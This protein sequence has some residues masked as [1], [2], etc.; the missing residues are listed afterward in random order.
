MKTIHTKSALFLSGLIL[1][2]FLIPCLT[3]AGQ[4]STEGSEISLEN[5]PPNQVDSILA[6][7]SNEQIRSLL[8][9]ELANTSADDK[10][11]NKQKDGLV[12]KASILLHILDKE[13]NMGLEAT[14]LFSS[15]AKIPS[16]YIQLAKNIGNGSFGAFI[17]A[18]LLFAAILGAAFLVEFIS[19]RF[20]ADFSRQFQ[21]KA[22]P[23]LDGPMRFIAGIMRAVPAVILILVFGTTAILL[24]FLTAGA[25]YGPQ[26]YLF[27][28]I[29]FI[30]LFFRLLSQLSRI[31][32]AP[33]SPSLRVLPLADST[34][35]ALHRSILVLFT[36]TFAVVI[37]LALFRELQMPMPSLRINVMLSASGLI[38]L[39]AIG[40]LR[41]RTS[42]R[43]RILARSEKNKTRNWVIEQFAAFWHVPTLLYFIIIWLIMMGDQ[44]NG[45]QRQNSAFLM[46]LLILP[47][48]VVFNNIG[49]WVVRLSIKT[50]RIYNS[51][52][53]NPEDDDYEEK[54]ANGEKKELD[55]IVT[56][57]RFMSLAILASLLIWVLEL[58]GIELP[59]ATKF[60]GA[61]F[62]A[63]IIIAL[64]L[65]FWRFASSYI[66]RKI[67]ESMPEKTDEEESDDEWGAAADR[68]RS[69]TL[70]PMLRKVLASTLLVMV[71]LL[72][73]SAMGMDIGPLLAGA[74]V[75]GLAIGFGAQKLVSDIF[76]GFFYL[77]DDAF[78]VGEYI[79]AGPVSG[80]VEAITLRNVMLRHHR[81]MLQ[82]VPHSDLG[83]ITNF[84]RGGIIVKFNL[85]FPYDANVDN[86]RKVIKKVG[87]AM[88]ED[89][90]FG[91]DF[92]NPVKSAGVREITG[93]VMVI[94]VK[95]KAQP[96]THFVIRR[97]AYRRITEALAAQGIHYAHRKVIVELPEHYEKQLSEQEKAIL[98]A[99]AA[100]EIAQQEE[101]AKKNSMKE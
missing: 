59:Y 98:K 41:I 26:R 78:R 14:S 29:L 68:G 96:G 71:T 77:L 67:A 36:Y 34:A 93:S 25:D 6:K 56:S 31:F 19:R 87:K 27:L 89:E 73:L 47:L 53:E 28:A 33:Q 20:T 85:E 52:A 80:A 84:M 54:V 66:E 57:G 22:I 51:E 4:V 48:F 10:T 46:S 63:L 83:S 23:D 5:V 30:I 45:I 91:K 3:T 11:V 7:L 72:V 42:V 97:E 50:L 88:L 49:Q 39:V 55:L 81:G 95:F 9:A 90:E 100:A 69:Y 58:W 35:L 82:I 75:L 92:I 17:L 94:R 15:V 44:I 86:I 60:A 32:C 12:Q 37:M 101:D 43:N 1:V 8:K 38:L 99:G 16:D 61:I 13:E 24:F 76:S 70:L 64:G 62:E 18:Q 21:E 79:Q 74:G 65:V 2:L 40:I